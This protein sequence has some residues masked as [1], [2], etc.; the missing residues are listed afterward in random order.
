MLIQALNEYYGILAKSGNVLPDGY[1]KVM[2]K[3]IVCLTSEGKIDSI[4]PY[5]KKI[6]LS[7]GKEKLVPREAVMPKR[8]EKSG[9]EANIIEHRPLYLFGLNY[10]KDVF[11]PEDRTNKAK[12]SHDAFVK[13][14]LKFL[15]EL[16]SPVINAYRS[17]ILNWNPESEINNEKILGIGKGYNNAGY[18]FCLTGYPDKLLHDDPKVKE[19]WERCYAA[20][21][22]E[23]IEQKYTAQCAVSGRI[24]PI[25]RTH[26]KIKGVYEGS[27]TG[28]VLVGCN[29]QSEFSYGLKQAY[30]SKISE[31][32]M[33]KYTEAL[34]YLLESRKHKILLD[35]MTVLFWAM[36]DKESS[37]DLLI[38]MMCGE[39]QDVLTAD[40]TE[41]M[42]RSILKSAQNGTLTKDG[43]NVLGDIDPN[44]DFYMVGLK[45]NSSRLAIKFIYRRKFG[46]ILFNVANYQKDIHVTEDM[47]PIPL[48]IIKKELT[49]EKKDTKATTALYAELIK[50]II[51][52]YSYPE[53]LIGLIVKRIKTD[54]DSRIS[55]VRAGIIKACINRNYAKREEITMELNLDNDNQA[56]LCGRLFAVLEKLQQEAVGNV[57][58]TI[59]DAYFASAASTPEL[60]FP[61]LIILA[62]NHLNK[63]KRPGFFNSWFE[64]IIGKLKEE[65]PHGTFSLQD[66]GRFIIG[67]YQQKQV[68][69]AKKEDTQKNIEILTTTK[70]EN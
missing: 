25:A 23:E 15:D 70:E 8:T 34:N 59:K 13:S 64:E 35:D 37:E 6:D 38:N 60:V 45:P 14:N 16:D 7:D 22:Q 50:S 40:Q 44:V 21:Q 55:P 9:I 11:T 20:K 47:H 57:N 28:S 27:T 33:N 53:E 67:Y 5:L 30:N 19:K 18:V 32:V 51:Y 52:G 2:I 42:L 3:Y 56:Y 43:L 26:G 4:M 65:F 48:Y 31:S 12:K 61:K 58:R 17:F 36:N 24:E 41:E 39:N 54:T 46:D 10:V 63:V 68:L 49:A 62:Q 69:Y 66:Q 1:S 29:N